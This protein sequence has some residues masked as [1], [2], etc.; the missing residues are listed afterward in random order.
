MENK[1]RKN[2]YLYLVCLVIICTNLSQLPMFVEIGETQFLSY[3]A[4]VFLAVCVAIRGIKLNL[5]VFTIG[6]LVLLF[7]IALGLLTLFTD[8]DYFNTRIFNSVFISFGV[9]I[10]SHLIPKNVMQ[11]DSSD[12][13]TIY[14]VY[15]FSAT[16]LAI[17]IYIM[18]FGSG[19]SLEKAIYAYSSKNST[20]QII[21]TAI[22]LALFNIR[23]KKSMLNVVIISSIVVNM[24]T[25]FLMRSRASLIGL[26]VI[27]FMILVNRNINKWVRIATVVIIAIFLIVLF[28]NDEFYKLII[29]DILFASRDAED[30]DSLSSG[31]FSEWQKFPTIFAEHPFIGRGKYKFESFPLS[32]LAQYGIFLGGALI[33]FALYPA[34]FAFRR[35]KVSMHYYILLTLTLVY[36]LNGIFEE[37]SPFGPGV[38]CYFIWF[39]LGIL[40]RSRENG[41]RKK[42]SNAEKW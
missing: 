6:V 15:M 19:F 41:E 37:L 5:K 23:R 12:F 36:L 26:A 27:A 28:V 2:Y 18:Y 7:G 32:V 39:M 17:V 1:S 14:Y 25:L 29:D 21:I 34:V 40:L 35:R 16:V 33:L 4:W 22:V 10:I 3:L 42:L 38:K 8:A 20:S 31:R 9:L 11:T 13:R 24:V 30:L